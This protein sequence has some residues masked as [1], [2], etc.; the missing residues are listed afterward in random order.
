ARVVALRGARRA[1]GGGPGEGLAAA[2]GF[3]GAAP[4]QGGRAGVRGDRG[5]RTEPKKPG[6]K[7]GGGGVAGGGRRP[8]SER[9][10]LV[11]PGE[12][13]KAPFVRWVGSWLGRAGRSRRTR[14]EVL[15]TV[16]GPTRIDGRSG[17]APEPRGTPADRR[18]LRHYRTAKPTACA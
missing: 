18:R 15:G 4:R 3:D 5:S 12:P 9:A 8:W 7:G 6:G 11:P 10:A 14:Y 16:A 2:G 1:A 13:V 17:L